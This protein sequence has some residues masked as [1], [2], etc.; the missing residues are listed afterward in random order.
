[1]NVSAEN[2]LH[3]LRKQQKQ[4]LPDEFKTGCLHKEPW[5]R[6][7]NEHKNRSDQEHWKDV[8]NTKHCQEQ[9]PL[10]NIVVQKEVIFT[11]NLNP[12][13]TSGMKRFSCTQF[14]ETSV[15]SATS[16]LELR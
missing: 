3:L 16:F 6:C 4:M 7:I 2:S 11:H 9:H 14:Y 8:D 10:S 5:T 1:M 12:R 13:N 15:F